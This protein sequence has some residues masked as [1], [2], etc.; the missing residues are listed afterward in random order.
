MEGRG[1]EEG[2]EM[3]EGSVPIMSWTHKLDIQT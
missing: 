1:D 3:K 2:E